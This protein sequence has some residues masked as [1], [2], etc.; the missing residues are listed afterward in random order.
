M[1][2]LCILA[3][4]RTE[5]AGLEAPTLAELLAARAAMQ[6]TAVALLHKLHGIWHRWAWRALDAEV[7]TLA[8]ALVAHGVTA[9]ERVIIAGAN[10]PRLLVGLL[11]AQR[12]GAVP[13]LVPQSGA[14]VP[15]P[16]RSRR[17]RRVSLWWPVCMR[18]MPCARPRPQ[19]SSTTRGTG[20]A[21]S[22]TPG[23]RAG[24]R[25]CR[26]PR[27]AC[28]RR[29]ARTT[30]QRWST[31][32]TQRMVPRRHAVPRQS[33]CCSAATRHW[34]GRAPLASS[35]WPAD[36][37]RDRLR[38]SPYIRDAWLVATPDR[39]LTALL[40]L[41]GDTLA[42]W[43]QSHGLAVRSID[44]L[45]AEERIHTLIAG[46]IAAAATPQMRI[47]AYLHTAGGFDT[48]SGETTP[49]GW[50]RPAVVERAHADALRHLRAGGGRPVGAAVEPE[51]DWA[52]LEDPLTAAAFHGYGI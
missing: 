30:L 25:S 49:E 39:D 16:Q 42:T 4:P 9:G 23:S 38:G 8:G 19:P 3:R 18:S 46:E 13:V 51:A 41:D 48:T 50:L 44:A 33:D 27:H 31:S 52:H 24:R 7:T 32:P 10:R 11:V 5:P 36:T 2:H 14:G 37:L 17:R 12:A 40:A 15:L 45:A 26:R 22:A 20:W 34:A 35:D 29:P 21:A 28:R 47:T 43:A 1:T 6:A